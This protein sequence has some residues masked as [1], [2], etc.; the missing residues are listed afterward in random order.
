[1]VMG[2]ITSF[3]RGIRAAFVALALC[4][5][6]AAAAQDAAAPAAEMVGEGRASYYGQELAGNRTAS[7]ERFDPGALTAAHRSLP[8]G[9][10]LRV[11]NLTNGLSAIVRVNDRGPFHRSRIVDISLAAARQLK[12]IAAGHARVRLE[13]LR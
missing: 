2:D 3:S 11:T 9:S 13:R 7:G 10:L 12:M 5:A 4:G 1:M 8:L 6:T